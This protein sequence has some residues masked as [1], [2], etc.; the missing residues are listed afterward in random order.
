MHINESETLAL[1]W[2]EALL[3]SRRLSCALGNSRVPSVTLV[4]S[5]NSRAFSGTLVA[6]GNLR[7]ISV[8]LVRSQTV[9]ISL[10]CDYNPSKFKVSLSFFPIS[11]INSQ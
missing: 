4:R 6:L 10:N 3:G 1:V 9:S 11:P 2:P 8:T 5:R 7:V